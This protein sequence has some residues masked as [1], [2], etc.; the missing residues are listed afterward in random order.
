M[1]AEYGGV[2]ILVNNAGKHPVH[3]AAAC[4][5]LIAKLLLSLSPVLPHLL[6]CYRV[7]VQGRCF[8]G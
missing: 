2:T 5:V 3:L 8:W 6:V 7:C 4:F 1:E